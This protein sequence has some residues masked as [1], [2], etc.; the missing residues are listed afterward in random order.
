ML[1]FK[2]QYLI[3]GFLSVFLLL[4]HTA[5]AQN[6]VSTEFVINYRNEF[7]FVLCVIVLFLSS[8]LGM[9]LP[10]EDQGKELEPMVKY[11]TAFLGGILAFIY[12]LY[13]D[14]SLTLLNPIWI[15]AASIALPVTILNIRTK[16]K[17]YTKVMDVT[18]HGE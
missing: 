7:T 4:T 18:K 11:I 16:I 3:M 17:E 12:C 2:F 13:R 1:R 8:W 6:S 9:K 14:K 10:A 5:Y 15:A